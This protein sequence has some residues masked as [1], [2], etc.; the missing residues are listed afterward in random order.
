MHKTTA[1]ISVSWLLKQF[2]FLPSVSTI[3]MS[4]LFYFYF[5]FHVFIGLFVRLLY[6]LEVLQ[7]IFLPTASISQHLSTDNYKMEKKNKA[8]THFRCF[9]TWGFHT[10]SLQETITR[11][12]SGPL[13]MLSRSLKMKKSNHNFGCF[14]RGK[15]TGL[16][17]F[18]FNTDACNFTPKSWTNITAKINMLT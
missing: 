1:S 14:K 10:M 7:Y 17:Y 16:R 9:K 4:S 11:E 2:K 8:V 6:A 18:R 12:L 5:F 3:S 15:S 13:H